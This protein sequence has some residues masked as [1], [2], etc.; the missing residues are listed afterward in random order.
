MLTDH[1]VLLIGS[2]L[3]CLFFLHR[4]QQ[5]IQAWQAF[6]GLPAYSILVSPISIITRFL[7]RIPWISHGVDFGWRNAYERR[8]Y[9]RV[10]SWYPTHGLYLGVFSAS[11]SD[12]VQLRS[13]FPNYRPQLLLAD[14]TPAK[15]GPLISYVV[16]FRFTLST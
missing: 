7:P 15:V 16:V 8:A 6:G 3:L 10:L 14:A 1:G 4:L 5:V 9:S 13:V 2:L 12:I 11:S